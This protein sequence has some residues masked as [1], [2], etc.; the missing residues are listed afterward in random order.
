MIAFLKSYP[1][2]LLA[3]AFLVIINFP[4]GWIGLAWFVHAAKKTGNTFFYCLGVCFYALSWVLLFSGIFLCGKDYAKA[5][6][7]KCHIPVFIIT[8][9]AVVSL[10]IFNLYFSKKTSKINE[11]AV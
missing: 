4:M 10:L 2:S 7:A 8:A 1:P 9:I 3:G 5:V 11:K 6:Y